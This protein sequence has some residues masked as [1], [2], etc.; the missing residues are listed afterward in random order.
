MLIDEFSA[1]DGDQLLGLLARAREAGI[2]VLLSTQEL[3]DLARV[4]PTFAAQV[5]A[6]TNVKLIHRQEVPDS[7][8]LLAGTIGT[9]T[10][11]EHTYAEHDPLAELFA[12]TVSTV[13]GSRRLVEKYKLHPNTFKNLTTGQAVLSIKAP[14]AMVGIVDIAPP[15]TH[16]ADRPD[17]TTIQPMRRH[18][19]PPPDSTPAPPRNPTIID[20]AGNLA[21]NLLGRATGRP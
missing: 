8:E 12:G 5:I 7:A 10:E 18:L 9:E 11:W 20:L 1:L 13:I 17:P 21:D 4:A 14:H 15:H 2:G 6:N 3:A 16:L 19:A